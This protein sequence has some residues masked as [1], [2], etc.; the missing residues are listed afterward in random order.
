M[1]PF[2][3]RHQ[4]NDPAARGRSL[5]EPDYNAYVRGSKHRSLL[6]AR[7]GGQPSPSPRR[8]GG[9]PSPSPR[10]CGGQP[11]P[12]PRRCGRQ[13]SPSPSTGGG[14]VG[15]LQDRRCIAWRCRI[16]TRS[17]GRPPS[18][19]G[20]ACFRPLR[21]LRPSHSA[22]THPH[23]SPHFTGT[24]FRLPSRRRSNGVYPVSGQAPARRATAANTVNHT[25]QTVSQ[26]PTR[27]K[28]GSFGLRRR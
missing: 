21:R 17:A 7:C 24:A 16:G 12:S 4:R 1:R 19:D 22:P 28:H 15:A 2:G 9:Q 25:A 13:P 14:R 23:V 10:R 20:P 8:C 18:D 27:T 6:D 11:S 5:R 3:Q 26:T